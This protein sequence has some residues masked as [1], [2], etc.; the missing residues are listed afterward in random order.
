LQTRRGVKRPAADWDSVRWGLELPLIRGSNGGQREASAPRS[1]T[2]FDCPNF[3]FSFLPPSVP[4]GV[5]HPVP[6]LVRVIAW[7]GLRP[8][9]KSAPVRGAQLPRAT[10]R[11]G[12]QALLKRLN[13][14]S[15]DKLLLLTIF[16]GI[17]YGSEALCYRSRV[18]VPI[19][20]LNS[21]FFF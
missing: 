17:A 8:E 14:P 2:Y 16:G 13:L 3:R 11:F 9:T 20:P 12:R 4:P 5:L 7:Q 18:R 1:R 21:F 10:R 6:Q 19:G 15:L